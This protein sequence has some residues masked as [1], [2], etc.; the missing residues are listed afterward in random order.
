[1]Q[2]G[3]FVDLNKII[4]DEPGLKMATS[5]K[6]FRQIIIIIIIIVVTTSAVMCRKQILHLNVR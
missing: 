5:V 1:M 6:N 2:S 3:C 4:A